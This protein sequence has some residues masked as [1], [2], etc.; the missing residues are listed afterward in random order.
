MPGPAPLY[1]TW[2]I[3]TPAATLNSSPAICMPTPVPPE[4]KLSLPGCDFAKSINSFTDF[5]GRLGCTSSTYGADAAK[6]I[7]VKSLLVSYGADFTRC[8]TIASGPEKPIN[9]V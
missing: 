9:S 1:G 2:V 7:G 6:V 4:A 3:L 8:G 5:T